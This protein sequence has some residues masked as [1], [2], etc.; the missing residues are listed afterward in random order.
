MIRGFE[1]LVERIPFHVELCSNG[2]RFPRG[3]AELEAVFPLSGTVRSLSVS[4]IKWTEPERFQVPV[5]GGS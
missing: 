4:V 1:N 3:I 2:K 5:G